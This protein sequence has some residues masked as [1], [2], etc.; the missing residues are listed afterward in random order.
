MAPQ[1]AKYGPVVVFVK[2]QIWCL[3]T[4][5]VTKILCESAPKTGGKHYTSWQGSGWHGPLEGHF[6]NTK[7]GVNALH[8][9]ISSRES[10][11]F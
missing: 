10:K 5:S 4:P 8:F 11:L 6:L 9:H 1:R 2:E 3:Y 7:Q